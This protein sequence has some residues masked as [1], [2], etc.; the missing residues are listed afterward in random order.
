M[1]N[2][3]NTY[4]LGQFDGE[5]EVLHSVDSANVNCEHPGEHEVPVEMLQSLQPHSVLPAKLKVKLRC[6]LIVMQDVKR[7]PS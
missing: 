7:Q 3:L 5:E 6:P 1:V 2:S 4:M